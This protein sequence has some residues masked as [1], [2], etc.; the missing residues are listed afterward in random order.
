MKINGILQINDELNPFLWKNKQLSPIVHGKLLEIAEDFFSKLDLEINLEDIT[1]TGSMANYNW[2]KYS[3]ID[4]HIVVDFLDVDDNEEL[5]REFF[6]SKT[7]NWNKNHNISF[8]GHEI[9]IYVQ[10]LN[11]EHFSTGVYSLLNNEWDVV[12]TKIDP[13]V[14][15]EMVKRKANSLIDMIERAEDMYLDKDYSDAYDF[16]LRLIKRIKKFRQSGLEGVGEYSNENLTFKYLR[17]HKYT[18]ILFGIRNNSYDRMMSLD[19]DHDRKFKIF[20]QKEDAPEESGF[21]RLNE[22]GKF[23]KSVKRRHMRQK[24]RLLRRGPQNPGGAYPKKPSYKRSKS[25]PTG[26]G[27]A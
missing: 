14:D 8:F 6:S 3:D 27:G 13:E 2:T 25:A 11:E 1:I 5:V 26:F 12:P 15:V 17:N 7:S 24:K 20:I 22:I 19:G 18:D 10:N 4:L 21:H 9:E 23:Q 16:S